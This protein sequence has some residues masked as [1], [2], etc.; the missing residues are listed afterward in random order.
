[1]LTASD[2][3]VNVLEFRQRTF[4]FD[5]LAEVDGSPVAVF[6]RTETESESQF[7]PRLVHLRLAVPLGWIVRDEAADALRIGRDG[8]GPPIVIAEAVTEVG[9][10]RTEF[11]EQGVDWKRAPGPG[12]VLVYAPREL[13]DRWLTPSGFAALGLG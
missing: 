10:E 4:Q 1:M 2:L 3:E 6:S 8:A 5:R 12:G 11:R 9:A 13:A 7:R